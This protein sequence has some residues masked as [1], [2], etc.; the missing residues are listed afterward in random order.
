M[1]EKGASLEVIEVDDEKD[2][3][4]PSASK[5]L[6]LLPGSLSVRTTEGKACGGNVNAYQYFLSSFFYLQNLFEV[7][8]LLDGTS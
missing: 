7:T 5:M 2:L 3:G 1:V 6:L 4:P 8:M